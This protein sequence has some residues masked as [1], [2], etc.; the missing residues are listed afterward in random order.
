MIGQGH[1]IVTDSKNIRL[2]VIYLETNLGA[3][4]H[5]IL[6]GKENSGYCVPGKVF[7]TT[8]QACKAFDSAETTHTGHYF[9]THERFCFRAQGTSFIHTQKSWHSRTLK[10][11]ILIPS[12][13]LFM[14][15]DCIYL[16]PDRFA[17]A[18]PQCLYLVEN[19][20]YEVLVLAFVLA[21]GDRAPHIKAFTRFW[22]QKMRTSTMK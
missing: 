11:F 15:P 17:F 2:L 20:T 9:G 22:G 6:S 3:I 18:H 5:C 1:T 8:V 21:E 4:T 12:V 14:H 10:S 7:L 16:R 19:R 13:H